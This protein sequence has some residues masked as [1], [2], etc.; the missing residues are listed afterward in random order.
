MIRMRLKL[1]TRLWAGFG[2]LVVLA[3]IISGFGVWNLNQLGVSAM[4]IAQ[5][6]V[7][8]DKLMQA[9]ADLETIQAAELRFTQDGDQSALLQLKKTEKH[10]RDTLSILAENNTTPEQRSLFEKLAKRMDEQ[11]ADSGKL[12]PMITT[13]LTGQTKLFKLGEDLSATIDTLIEAAGGADRSDV[14]AAAETVGRMAMTMR[15]TSLRFLSTR[16]PEGIATF[17][18]DFYHARSALDVFSALAD[19][20]EKTREPAVRTALNGYR[21]SFTVLAPSI[22]TAASLYQDTQVPRLRDMRAALGQVGSVNRRALLD[23]ADEADQRSETSANLQTGA[24]LFV[25]IAGSLLGVF[26]VRGIVRPLTAMTGTMTALA[27]G[28]MTVTVPHKARHDEIGAMARAVEVFQRNAME[29]A[30]LA[31]AEAAEREEKSRRAAIL[32]DLTGGFANQAEGLVDSLGHAAAEMEASARALGVTAGDANARSD[33]VAASAEQASANVQAVAAAAEELT[34][35][36]TE[37]GRQV[38]RSTLTA[39][40]AVAEAKRTDGVVRGLSEEA[41]KVGDIVALINAIASQTSLLALNATIEAARAGEAGKGFAVVAS[42]V[43]SLAA[44]TAKATE[45]IATQVSR[46]QGA[47]REA[48]GAIQTISGTIDEVS[49]I[50]TTI[51]AAVEQQH[52]ATR[53]IAR[54]VLQAADGTAEVTSHIATVRQA[55]NDTGEEAS[56][57]LTAAGDVARQSGVLADAVTTFLRAVKAA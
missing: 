32:D 44:Q 42:E 4:A 14:T 22:L 8:Q 57:V 5:Q 39:G 51:A 26:T 47:T 30:R 36:I 34:A 37:I 56:H 2:L 31:A 17:Q 7:L 35:S 48:V 19:E 43:K 38:E 16:D 11:I 27:G 33:A 40:Q 54:N 21:N 46:I 45:E 20:Q 29:A 18:N 15:V 28:D 12:E 41:R 1:S 23:R 25:L 9:V 55:A 24:A 49:Q 13:A 53:E 50:A 10:A 6:G 52:A 3:L